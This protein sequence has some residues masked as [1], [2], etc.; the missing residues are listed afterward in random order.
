MKILI[1]VFLITLLCGFLSYGKPIDR[2]EIIVCKDNE[3]RLF[4][5]GEVRHFRQ[6]EKFFG[7]DTC[8]LSVLTEDKW[9]R[10]LFSH[11]KRFGKKP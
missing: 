2:V 5:A 3:K 7:Q 8:K 4:F 1:L 10:I 9:L 11:Q 6:F